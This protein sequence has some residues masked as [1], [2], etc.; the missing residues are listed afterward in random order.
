MTSATQ[1]PKA[2]PTWDL[3]SIFP[4]GASSE[5]FAKHRK[6]VQSDLTATE[7]LLKALPDTIDSSS[8]EKWEEFILAMQSVLADIEMVQ[9]FAGCL[10]AQDVD[11]ATANAIE[12]EGD[13]YVADWSKLLAGLEALAIKQTDQQWAILT[14]RESIKGI[15]FVLNETRDFARSKMSLEKETLALDLSVSGY[16][17]WSR[18]YDKMA[19]EL[20][21]DF[22]ED[23]ITKSLSMG[24]LATKLSSPDRDVRKRAFDAISSTWFERTDLASMTLNSI[25]GFRWSLYDARGWDSILSE[26]LHNARLSEPSLDAMWSVISKEVGRLKPYI[27][28]KKKLLSIDKFSWWDEFAPC[29]K[30][31]R[32]IAF[33]E[34]GKFIADNVGV[35]SEDMKQFVNMAIDKRWVEAEDR[36][37]KAGGAFCTGLGKTYQSRVFMTYSGTFDSLLTLAHELGHAYHGWVIKDRPFL[38]QQYPMPLAETASIF[39]ETLVTDAAMSQATDTQ[40]KLMLLDQKL[41]AAYVFF[42]DLHCRFIFERSFYTERH[43]GIVATERLSELMI[44]AQK[45]AYGDLLDESGYHPLFWCTKLHFYITGAP[46]YN[47]PY[48]FGFLFSGGVYDRARKEGK[49][50][51][52]GYASLLADTGSMTCEDV[53]KKHLNLDLAG[54][55]FWTDAVNRSLADVDEFVRLVDSV[56]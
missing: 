30:S 16:H 4:G 42:C 20:R 9:A 2:A 43:K 37:G 27:E 32:L 49:A 33:D 55:Q 18:L 54:E 47:F 31:D 1:K 35:F 29:G 39:A 24:Q 21:A 40:E 45:K 34:A 23:G 10:T 22:E 26:P 51:A 11:D 14:E 6:Q 8:V 53:A 3:E 15:D 38:S 56:A 36:A 19:G 13:Q 50:F 52:N 5:Q 28:A 25:G 41:Q 12:G 17:A 44:E 48:T 7:A 46:F